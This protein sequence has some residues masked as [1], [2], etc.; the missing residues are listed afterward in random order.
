[1]GFANPP[2]RWPFP[3]LRGVPAAC[4]AGHS[5]VADRTLS[6]SFAILWSFSQRDLA[7]PPKRASPSH[8]LSLPTAHAGFADPLARA[9]PARF[10]PPSGFGHPLDGLLSTNP[11]R[12]CFTPTALMGFSLRSFL[13][14]QGIRALPPG[15]THIPFLSPLFP[16]HEATERTGEPRFL[17]FD[18]CE[19]PLT[20]QTCV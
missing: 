2:C 6:S 16:P 14:S 4:F 17:G 3:R 8:G 15:S 10:V 11:R 9:L 5:Q 19:S 12:L 1:M 7:D 18:P 20:A 13:L